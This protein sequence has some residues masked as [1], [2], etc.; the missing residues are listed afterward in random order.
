MLDNSSKLPRADSQFTGEGFQTPFA[1]E[2]AGLDASRGQPGSPPNR[3][4]RSLARSQLRT[5]PQAGPKSTSLSR[6]GAGEKA[7][8]IHPRRPRRT[9]RTAVNARCRDAHEEKP[10][11]PDIAGS[12]CLITGLSVD[13]HAELYDRTARRVSP[14]SDIGVKIADNGLGENTN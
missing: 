2:R 3:V 5:A 12:Q 1:I 6:G 7:A 11:E 9:D 10:V 8:S 14:F 4:H 13:A